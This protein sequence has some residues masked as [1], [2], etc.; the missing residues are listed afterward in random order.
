[1]RTAFFLRRRL[2]AACASAVFALLC[3][4]FSASAD[5]SPIKI[6]VFDFELDDFSAGAGIAGNVA[7]DNE[8]LDQATSEVRGLLAES[9]RYSLVDVSGVQ[10]DSVKARAFRQC[11]G[12]ESALAQKLGADQSFVGVITRVSRTEFTVRFQI[13]DARTGDVI[14]N[15]ATDLRIGADYAWGRGAAS[16]IKNRLLNDS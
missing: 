7:A 14:A 6:A 13:R 1:M 3:A 11:N 9:G 5:S 10:S 2:L 4:E 12:C 15:K 16:L 8:H